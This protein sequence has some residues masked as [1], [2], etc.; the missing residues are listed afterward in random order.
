MT[1]KDAASILPRKSW[2]CEYKSDDEATGS[3]TLYAACFGSVD[4]QGDIIQPGAVQNLDELTRD[5][6]VALNHIQTEL[7]V[8]MI[9][10]AIQDQKGL[11][12]SGRWHT[13]E[14][15]QNCRKIVN[16]RMQAGKRVLCSVGYVVPFDGESYEKIDGKT[17]R[18]LSKISVY[19]CSFVNLPANP[20][21]EVVSAKSVS[22]FTLDEFEE[23][24]AVMSSDE[25]VI[26]AL[27]RLLGLETKAGRKMSG[28]NLEK[29]KSIA[30]GIDDHSNDVMAEAKGLMDR[31]KSLKVKSE[32]HKAMGEEFTKTL[33]DLTS[34][35]QQ[36]VDEDD[37]DIA[38]DDDEKELDD[39]DDEQEEKRRKRRKQD[40]DDDEEEASSKRRKRRKEDEE[41][42]Q[43]EK[44]LEA[45]RIELKRRALLLKYPGQAG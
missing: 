25:G 29:F 31:C 11:L 15:A 5:G 19:E 34:G 1:A 43:E 28:A 39:D 20:E 18:R 33:K 22:D 35:Q 9:D 30:K 23:L 40:D 27:K 2:E 7:P 24:E 17:V 3:F 41:E 32:A 26:K 12:I 10:T 21:A 45:Y 8:A 37:D 42:D 38:E 4:R 6:W 13:T 14:A 36:A 16:E 44:A